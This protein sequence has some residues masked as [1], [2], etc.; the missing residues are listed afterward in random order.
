MKALLCCILVGLC[1]Q[2]ADRVAQVVDG[3]IG[4]THVPG[5]ARQFQDRRA[6]TLTTERRPGDG[7]DAPATRALTS[8]SF[9][10]WVYCN[11]NGEGMPRAWLNTKLRAKLLAVGAAHDLTGP[12][13]AKL[14]RAGTGD[15]RRLLDEIEDRRPWFEEIRHD[16]DTA[17]LKIRELGPLA[18]RFRDGPFEEGSL[19]SKTLAKILADRAAAR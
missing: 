6:M 11:M 9:D 13:L 12:E 4:P 16:F 10:T 18:D 2:P 14:H 15:N 1:Q 19:L 8:G 3:L 5:M 7:E 17:R